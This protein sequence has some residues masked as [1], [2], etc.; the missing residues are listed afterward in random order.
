MDSLPFGD[1]P[2]TIMWSRT[3]S[4]ARAPLHNETC[5]S[6]KSRTRPPLPCEVAVSGPPRP[7]A[8]VLSGGLR[9]IAARLVDLP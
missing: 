3:F 5:A 7:G 6:A 9:M 4:T 8:G 1:S 2:S